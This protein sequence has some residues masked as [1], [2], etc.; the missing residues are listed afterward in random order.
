MYSEKINNITNSAVFR[1]FSNGIFT[2]AILP[3]RLVAGSR[4]DF[5]MAYD[6]YD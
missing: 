6:A 4:N 3:A 5:L 2:M 1:N